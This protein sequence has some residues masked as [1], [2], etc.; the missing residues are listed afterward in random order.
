MTPKSKTTNPATFFA[1]EPSLIIGTATSATTLLLIEFSHVHLPL[2]F[3]PVTR[4]ASISLVVVMQN[5]ATSRVHGNDTKI[6][7]LCTSG[8]MSNHSR[9]RENSFWQD[10][11]H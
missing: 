8:D 1:H 6:T 10:A 4:R 5:S 3:K 7:A 2:I 11:S 9:T